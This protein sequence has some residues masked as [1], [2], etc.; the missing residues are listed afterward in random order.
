M[1]DCQMIF[2]WGVNG[3]KIIEKDEFKIQILTGAS[4]REWGN[5]P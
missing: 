1:I 4:D 3:R 5:D 2:D